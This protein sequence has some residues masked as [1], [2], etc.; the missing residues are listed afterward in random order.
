MLA[1]LYAFPMLASMLPQAVGQKVLPFLPSNAADAVTE[2]APRRGRTAAWAGLALY[3]GYAGVTLA[4]AALLLK[5][6]DA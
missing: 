5:R 4:V 2:I 1:V 3:A 6:R